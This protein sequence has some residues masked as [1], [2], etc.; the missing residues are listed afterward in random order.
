M[1]RP[2]NGM[3]AAV[4][5]VA[6]AWMGGAGSAAVMARVQPGVADDP[7]F[8]MG[9]AGVVDSP[10]PGALIL[11]TGLRT[12]AA[13]E[14]RS[15]TA[16]EV[17]YI[18]ADGKPAT[19]ARGEVLAVAPTEWAGGASPPTA[20]VE[21]EQAMRPRVQLVDGSV[22]VGD[23]DTVIAG[24]GD[25]KVD[26]EIGWINATLG[27]RRLKLDQ[28]ARLDMGVRAGDA[29]GVE[30]LAEKTTARDGD[31]LVL[32]SGEVMRGFIAGFQAVKDGRVMS[33]GVR[34]EVDK[35]P[36]TIPL[37]RVRS[38]VL[39]NP[40]AEKRTGAARVWLIDGSSVVCD[41]FG[42]E[43]ADGVRVRIRG[44]GE[45]VKAVAIPAAQVWG[46]MFRL[47][48]TMALSSCAIVEQSAPGRSWF[49][50]VRVWAV[51]GVLGFEDVYLPGAMSVR[52]AMPEGARRLSCTLVLPDDSRAYADLS[53]TLESLNDRGEVVGAAVRA[54]LNGGSPA[55]EI[56]LPLTGEA[57]SV[58]ITT[59]SDAPGMVHSKLFIR[60]GAVLT[61]AA[62]KEPPAKP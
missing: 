50:P 26:E 25:E 17:R 27:V 15:I 29:A 40:V 39:S 32:R 5:A 61:E 43:T 9:G 7:A 1:M 37:S 38:V 60:R 53:A 6:I 41:E 33:A 44:V 14:I 12:L 8:P 19:V 16:A 42:Q 55:V 49:E 57:K 47:E 3:S 34:I 48:Q 59:K 22:I 4:V 13:R 51:G 31:A 21:S 35:A 52:F 56:T 62:L 2:M 58:R 24:P 45:E 36:A 28:I 30:S 46:V 11:L 23:L 10:R 20:M 54:K 18:G